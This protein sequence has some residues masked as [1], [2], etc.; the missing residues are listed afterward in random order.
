MEN[1]HAVSAGE[2]EDRLKIH[3]QRDRWEVFTLIDSCWVTFV[4]K[5]SHAERDFW[6][7]AGQWIAIETWDRDLRDWKFV[8]DRRR[9]L[10]SHDCHRGYG[11]KESHAIQGGHGI[12]GTRQD[13]AQAG[14][15]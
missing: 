11:N 14:D 9:V 4:S 3:L 10:P 15:R 1:L 7:A 13:S 8:T 6:L 5:V 2:G 12:D